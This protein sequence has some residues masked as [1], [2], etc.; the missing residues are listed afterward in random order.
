M[1]KRSPIAVLLLPFITCGIYSWYW[2]VKT[3]GE[4]NQ[5]NS[6]QPRIPTAWIWLIPFIGGIYWYWKYS[7]GAARFTKESISQIL[8]FVVLFLLGP[9]G[10]AILQDSYNKA[11]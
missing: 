3:K 11:K 7:E 4:L 9:V 2:V 5:E 8:A 10:H 1:K 6:D